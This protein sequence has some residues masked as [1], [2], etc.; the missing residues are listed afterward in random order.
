MPAIHTVEAHDAATFRERLATLQLRDMIEIT[1]HR[2]SGGTQ[3]LPSRYHDLVSL[4]CFEVVAIEARRFDSDDKLF[5]VS[6]C[7]EGSFDRA[8][9]RAALEAVVHDLRESQPELSC[10]NAGALT[11]TYAY[12]QLVL[13]VAAATTAAAP[14]AAAGDQ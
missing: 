7:F 2:W 3:S 13:N 6:V 14:A 4:G 11:G 1:K 8:S 5:F 9:T 10:W 12:P